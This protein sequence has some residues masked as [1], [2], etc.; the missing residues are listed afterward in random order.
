MH[1]GNMLLVTVPYCNSC[2]LLGLMSANTCTLAQTD[3]GMFGGIF[4]NFRQ[5]SLPP[6]SSEAEALAYYVSHMSMPLHLKAK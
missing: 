2:S 5:V 4:E 6:F 3:S 1:K